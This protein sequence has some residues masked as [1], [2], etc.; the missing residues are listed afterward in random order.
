MHI[1][2][3]VMILVFGVVFLAELPDKSLFA[4]LVLGNRLPAF[5]VWLGV[6]T[7][8]LTHVLIAVLAGHLL[9]LLP[10]WATECIVAALFLVGGLLLLFGKHG[11]EEALHHDKH[12]PKDV[13]NPFKV[14]ATAYGVVFIGEWGDITQI[15]TANYAAKYH[16][17]LSVAIGATAA[18]WL[19]AALAVTAGTRLLNRVPAKLLLRLM[20]LIMLLFA[21]LSL[22]SA[23]R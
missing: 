14:F 11:V 17:P 6:A 16:A 10:H 7:A 23:F 22:V 2:I 5:W 20:G 18:L 21:A 13:H 3:G 19:V 8:F 9:T 12:A 4:T 1:D 15:A